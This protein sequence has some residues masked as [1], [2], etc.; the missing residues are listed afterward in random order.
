[1]PAHPDEAA[2]RRRTRTAAA[3]ALAA[4]CCAV[5]P[6]DAVAAADEG[7]LVRTTM[8]SEVGVVLDE[9]P[10]AMRDDVARSVTERP[11]SF[12][13]GLATAQVRLTTYRLIFRPAFYNKPKGTL[14]LPPE[15]VWD[16]RLGGEPA[17]N[18]VNGHDVVSVPYVFE[19]VLLSDEASPGI[20]EPKLRRAG[21]TWDEPFVLPVD[22]ELVM[23]RTG[24]ACMDESQFPFASVDSEEVDTFYDHTAVV[25]RELSKDGY[26]QTVM[27]DRSCVQ[28][29]RDH[30]GKVR[31]SVHYE[32][33]PWDPALARRYE[34]GES[35]S[36]DPDLSTY[37][38]DFA[39]SRTNYRYV[40]QS[41][42]GGCEV[43]EGSVGGTGWR[44][45]LQFAT[46]D[47]NVGNRDLTIGGVDYFL[48]GTPG[49]LDEHNLYEWSPCH[50]HYHFKYYGDLT[51]SGNGTV[52]NAKK[53]FCLQS[54]Y[55]VANRVTS[56]LHNPFSDCAYQ[57]V[58]PG[59]V[60]QYKAGLS[61]QWI[62][63]TDLPE[64]TGYRSFRTN[65]NGF[66]CEG[67]FVDESGTPLG[68]TDPVVWKPTGLVADNGAPVEAPLCRLL[69][70]WDRNNSHT[71]AETIEP[72]GTG[73]I[74]D[75]CARGQIG[76]LRNCG[77]VLQPET[78]SC[79]PG[80]RTKARFAVRSGAA[81]QVVRLTEYS[82]VLR[83]AIPARYEDSWVPLQP[84]VSDQPAMLGNA[85]AMPGEP[86]KLTFHCPSPRTGGEY[87]PGGRFAVYTA[88]VFGEDPHEPVVRRD[89]D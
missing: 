7:S 10:E 42:S 54:T 63:T 65:P 38:P 2:G 78:V 57:G 86:A 13:T 67:A 17:R 50:G 5:A 3:W 70:E 60:D 25:E 27:P 28:A 34:V 59:W 35:T 31:T 80:R 36:E 41:G 8:H 61:G 12:W 32:R 11:D 85:V 56:P 43:E 16:I 62:D 6:A 68:P 45:L 83:T 20:S 44:R 58:S 72:H 66:L 74:T 48:S 49:E 87:E 9:I 37:L 53:G 76:P 1:M 82:H 14:P 22:P 77:F 46:S 79:D 64:G 75:D 26:H 4:A 15:A 29:L 18:R 89:G 24:Y 84:G 81:P 73:Q 19:S 33:L 52:E 88:P 40:H 23:Q 71:T 51:W 39:P 21:G 55:R 30:V 69:R 47:E